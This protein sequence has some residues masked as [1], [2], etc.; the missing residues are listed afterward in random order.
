MW[1]LPL[2]PPPPFS[3][4][5]CYHTHAFSLPLLPSIPKSNPHPPTT[6]KSLATAI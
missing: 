2:S 1:A 3:N 4:P 6:P 5:L